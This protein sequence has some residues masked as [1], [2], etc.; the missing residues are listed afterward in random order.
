MIYFNLVDLLNLLYSFSNKGVEYMVFS[1]TH[2]SLENMY[3]N[4]E[5][6]LYDDM[7]L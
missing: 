2:L 7:G 6:D 4:S 1:P 5:G 3:V